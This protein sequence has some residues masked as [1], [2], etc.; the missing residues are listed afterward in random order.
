MRRA[1]LAVAVFDTPVR[2]VPEPGAYSLL[3]IGLVAIGVA[4]FLR[5]GEDRED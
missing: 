2:A 4:W 3:V 5:R 1:A